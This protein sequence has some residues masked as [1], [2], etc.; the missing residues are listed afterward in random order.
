MLLAI[1]VGNSTIAIGLFDGDRLRHQWRIGTEPRRTPDETTLLLAGLLDNAGAKLAGDVHGVVVGSVVPHVTDTF[2]QVCRTATSAEPLIVQPGV[3]TGVGLRHDDPKDLGAD[4]IA[5]AVA[6]HQLYGGP[7]VVVDFGTAISVDAVDANGTFIG[8]A[9]APGVDTATEALIGKAA[10]LPT[11]QLTAP[12]SPL[13]R[14]TVAAMQAGVVYG[15]AGLVDGLVGRI[16]LELGLG[17]TTVA[18]G[19]SNQVV[20]EACSTIDHH[21]PRLTLKGL[22]LIWERNPA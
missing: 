2:I 22:R 18:T 17:V 20:R 21:D 9:I 3:R 19:G 1:D 7:A 6:V 5:N 10:R 16:S 4:R 14:S 11:V 8:G 13:G 12:E 15:F